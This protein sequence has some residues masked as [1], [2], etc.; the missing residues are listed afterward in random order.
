MHRLRATMRITVSLACL[1]LSVL[2]TAQ[3]L[4]VLPDQDKAIVNGRKSLSEAVAIDCSL[5]AQRD[6]MELIEASLQAIVGREEDLLSAALRSADGELLVAVGN[7]EKKWKPNAERLSTPTQMYVPIA[8][9]GEDWGTVELRFAQIGSAGGWM[10]MLG[11]T[12]RFMLFVV[13]AGFLVHFLYLRRVLR[14]LDPTRVIPNRVRNT[15]DTLAEG[16]VVLDKQQ[17]I[18]FANQSFSQAVGKSATELQGHEVA[19]FDWENNNPEG[20]DGEYP[21]SRAIRSGERETGN[22]LKLEQEE[23]GKRVFKVNTAPVLTED[24]RKMGALASFDDVTALEERNAKLRET[25]DRLKNSRDQIRRQNDQLRTMAMYD[26]LTSCLNRRFFFAEF[27]QSLAEAQ[28]QRAPLSAILVDVDHFKSVNDNH[29]HQVG[30][31]VLQEVAKQLRTGAESHGTVCRYG[32]EEFAVLLPNMDFAAA[33]RFADTLRGRLEAALCAGLPITAS[34]G[35]SSSECGAKTPQDLLEQA[36]QALYHAKDSG[37]N[38]VARWDDVPKTKSKPKTKQDD[39]GN[40]HSYDGAEAS[41]PF[42]AVT[43]LMSAL[44]YRDPLTAEHSR[45]VADLCVATAAGLMNERERYVLEVGALLHDIGKLG[46]PDAVLLKPGPL[47]AAERKIIETHDWIGVEILAAAFTSTE[48]TEIVRNH[49]AWFGGNRRQ[50]DLPSGADIPL[51]A[52]ILSIADAYDAITSDRVYRRGKSAEEAITEMRRWAGEQFD[53]ELLER[54]IAVVQAH[55]ANEQRE[56]GDVTKQTA[57][58]IGLQMEKL[59]CALDTE[60]RST[61]KEMT[62]LLKS[63]ATQFDINELAA[64]ASELE[65]NLDAEDAE[66]CQIVQIATDMLDLCRA[67]QRSYF[68]S[69]SVDEAEH[70]RRKAMETVSG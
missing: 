68:R 4:G 37:R 3:M 6:D 17:R 41:I 46:V 42:H 27:E 38:Q 63:T 66:W 29:G 54:F 31:R 12:V 20:D 33:T 16:L 28:Q 9:H 34:M 19:D 57:L 40:R 2:L 25:L 11:P 50:P 56:A 51:G 58:R 44:H 1:T 23:T 70:P 69:E 5:A 64:A 45:R 22:L 21:W 13:C 65:Q 30:D 48:L 39:R 43:A 67:T 24:G 55:D 47:N 18:V 59:V 61:L 15:L 8:A 7:H 10:G 35:V 36:D 14:H 60:D 26:P 53:P 32:G 62:G 49:H 52:R